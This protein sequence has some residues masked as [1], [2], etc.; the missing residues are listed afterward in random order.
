MEIKPEREPSDDD[1]RGPEH[2]QIHSRS[3]L[4]ELLTEGLESGEA[5][6]VTDEWWEAKR[7]RR[8]KLSVSVR[9][10]SRIRR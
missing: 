7:V 8:R 1:L 9:I 4:D 10:P 5:I 2:L 6:E 3:Q